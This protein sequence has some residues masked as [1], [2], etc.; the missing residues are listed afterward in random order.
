[1]E[2]FAN[3]LVKVTRIEYPELLE[4]TNILIISD[5]EL[6]KTITEQLSFRGAECEVSL[7][8]KTYDIIIVTKDADHID[9]GTH[10]KKGGLLIDASPSHQYKEV[11]FSANAHYRRVRV[12]A[13]AQY[14]K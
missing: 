9:L 3:Q 8:D 13:I 11:Q 1:M 4:G 2:N 5:D 14:L 10:I 7:S 12:V 6:A